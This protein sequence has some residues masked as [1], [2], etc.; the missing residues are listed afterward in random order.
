VQLH[1]LRIEFRRAEQ[2]LLTDE[3]AF[4]DEEVVLPPRRWVSLAVSHGVRDRE[5]FEQVDA[6]RLR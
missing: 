4:D 3:Y 5:L 6:G 1:R 2:V